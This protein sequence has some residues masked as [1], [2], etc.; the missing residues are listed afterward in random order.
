MWS[1]GTPRIHQPTASSVLR[2][3]QDSFQ[4]APHLEAHRPA[5]TE[6]NGYTAP[7]CQACLRL[8]RLVDDTIS[9]PDQGLDP[10]PRR[11]ADHVRSLCYAQYSFRKKASTADTGC[12]VCG[13]TQAQVRAGRLT[14]PDDDDPW[15][16][17]DLA[18][19]GVGQRVKTGS[20]LSRPF[21]EAGGL[22]CIRLCV[23]FRGESRAL[24]AALDGVLWLSLP[25]V[26]APTGA[27]LWSLPSP[28]CLIV[29]HL[30][31]SRACHGL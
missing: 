26:C 4:S 28:V 13:M 14:W 25:P 1:A 15:P 12:H 16:G 2:R 19:E 8:L 3:T 10:S 21:E 24:F 22:V 5:T 17:D 20:P 30:R 6:M 9:H 18:R 27:G 29:S 23:D 7:L 31:S 11:K